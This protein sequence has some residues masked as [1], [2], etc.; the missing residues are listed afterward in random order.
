MGQHAERLGQPPLR[1][2][3]GGIALV[4]DGKGRFKPLVHQIGVEHSHLFGQH[5]ALVNDRAARQRGQIQL[6]HT[7]GSRRFFNA[8]A[9]DIQ[10]AFKLLFIHAFG[11]GNQDLLDLGAG[12]IGLVAQAADIHRHM[13]PAVNVIAHAQHFGFH[14][15]AAGFLRAKIGARQKHLAHS[16]QLVHARLVAGAAD[17]VVKEV[18]R[19]LH[20]NARAIAG[21]AIGIYRATVPN[22]L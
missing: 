11:I 17:L 21:F 4:I 10:L 3:V 18:Y 9:N 16:H 8:A 6:F 19:D 22:G 2:G 20:V 14:D 7:R 15:R 5:H 1:E 13:A 12:G